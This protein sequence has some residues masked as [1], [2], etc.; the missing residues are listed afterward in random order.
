M[1]A[2]EAS[3]EG[4]RTFPE[5]W[6]SRPQAP[7]PALL[8]PGSAPRP[9][10]L[11]APHPRLCPWGVPWAPGR[12]GTMSTCLCE[13]EV[14]V[15]CLGVCV[16]PFGLVRRSGEKFYARP[17]AGAELIRRCALRRVRETG[18]D[19]EMEST[20]GSEVSGFSA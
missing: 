3:E 20:V 9:L 7:L 1:K 6:A 10:P 15:W 13:G 12:D 5:T 19:E 16:R 4:K 8:R 11:S 14:R 17:R 18:V 2:R